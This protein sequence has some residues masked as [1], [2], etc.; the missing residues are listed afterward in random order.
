[1]GWTCR[2]C[3]RRLA[4]GSVATETGGFRSKRRT[5]GGVT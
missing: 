2:A 4:K 1:L 3:E 5:G